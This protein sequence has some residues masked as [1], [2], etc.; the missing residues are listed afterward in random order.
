MLQ[1]AAAPPMTKRVS[2]WKAKLAGRA[3]EWA[4]RWLPFLSGEPLMT[5]F[6]ASQMST[7]HWY[8]ITAARRY[9]GY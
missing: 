4:Y 3:L 9:L 6:V 7:S 2:A 1:E 5:R 8:E